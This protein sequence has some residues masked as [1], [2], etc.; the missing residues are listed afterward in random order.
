MRIGGFDK[1]DLVNFPE[2]VAATVFVNGCNFRCPYCHNGTLV[3]SKAEE[4]PCG[5]VWEYLALRSGMVK[6][7]VISGGEPTL[8][9]DLPS[10]IRQ[11]KKLGVK[12]KLDTNGS[13]PKML[14]SLLE[15]GLLDYVAMDIKTSIQ[16]YPKVALHGADEVRQSVK[17]LLGQKNVPYEFRTTCV[18]KLIEPSDFLLIGEWISEARRYVLQQ[19][20]PQHTLDPALRTYA[21]YTAEE[22]AS[23][24]QRLKTFV[25]DI[26]IR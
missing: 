14:A 2:L 12:V 13:N 10:F 3:T 5:A 23:L 15:E 16:N 9:E 19:F 11:A 22:L 24:A 6:G 25:S 21:S 18:K 20:C 8:Y 7:L 4:I 26:Q 1:L 17:I